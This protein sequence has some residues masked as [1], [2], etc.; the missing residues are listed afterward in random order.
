MSY[1]QRPVSDLLR[2]PLLH[3]PQGWIVLAS[4]F[5]CLVLALL[6]WGGVLDLPR[7]KTLD[8]VLTCC[9][10]WPF[11][12]FLQ[13]LKYNAPDFS[14]SWG[15]ALLAAILAFAPIAYVLVYG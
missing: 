9:I 5:V 6:Y 11:I 14:P 4:A 13:F 3:T 12:T 15:N 7:A 1:D 2:G 10:F 8:M